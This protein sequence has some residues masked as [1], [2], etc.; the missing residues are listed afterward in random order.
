MKKLPRILV[1]DDQYG[2]VQN[3]VNDDRKNFCINL[4]LKDITG[5]AASV[6]IPFPIADAIFHSGVDGKDFEESKKNVIEKVKEGWPSPDGWRW[7][8]ILLDRKFILSDG[9][10]NDSFGNEIL[11]M[12]V[13]VFPDPDV[14][15][16]NC[17]IPIVMLSAIERI[18]GG[19]QANILGAL[20]YIEKTELDKTK[21][22]EIIQEYGLIEDNSHLFLGNS[23]RL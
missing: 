16:G 9:C 6:S 10:V 19:Q 15:P 1:I 3:E 11:K 17:E 8:L 18:K 13:K 12:L 2:I 4:G 22:N 5:D 23:L 7:A 14:N 21:L 20:H